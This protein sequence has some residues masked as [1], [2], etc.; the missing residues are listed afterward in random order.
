MDSLFLYNS[1]EEIK[2]MIYDILRILTIQFIVQLLVSVNNPKIPFF[3]IQFFQVSL[4]LILGIM[5][6]WMVIYKYLSRNK[7]IE[8]YL[9]KSIKE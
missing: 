2:P 3:S 1:S 6:F 4:F 5:V 8:K 7:I 9:E